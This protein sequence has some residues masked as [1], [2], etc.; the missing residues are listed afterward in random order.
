MRFGSVLREKVLCEWT[1]SQWICRFDN[2]LGVREAVFVRPC[3]LFRGITGK[4]HNSGKKLVVVETVCVEV[5]MWL[6]SNLTEKANCDF[7][8]FF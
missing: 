1:V 5:R 6:W 8:L 3:F 7:R 4:K 2:R